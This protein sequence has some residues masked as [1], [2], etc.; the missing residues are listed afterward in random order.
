AFLETKHRR[1]RARDLLE[2]FALLLIVLGLVWK[3]LRSCVRSAVSQLGVTPEPWEAFRKAT[4]VD[5]DQPKVFECID[6]VGLHRQRLAI[7]CFGVRELALL[8]QDVAEIAV[9]RRIIGCNR[10][11]PPEYDL[12]LA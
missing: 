8:E 11:E 6:H 1:R 4:T 7:R 2:V 12:S 3:G 5:N 9:R 10:R